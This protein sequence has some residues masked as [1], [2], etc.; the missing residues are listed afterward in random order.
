MRC[1]VPRL[2]KPMSWECGRG[3]GQD[4]RSRR[5]WGGEFVRGGVRGG[6]GEGGR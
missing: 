3:R 2:G 6:A 4:P 1:L 5:G